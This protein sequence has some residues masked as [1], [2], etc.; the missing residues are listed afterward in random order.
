MS[1]IEQLLAGITPEMMSGITGGGAQAPMGGQLSMP[2][3]M[4]MAAQ[5]PPMPQAPP[6]QPPQD[7]PMGGL[8]GNPL[9]GAGMGLLASGYDSRVN[10]WTSAM[11]GMMNMQMMKNRSQLT[12]AKKDEIGIKQENLKLERERMK[13]VSDMAKGA[14]KN[15]D[16]DQDGQI[17]AIEN[18]RGLLLRLADQTGD[19]KYIA[20]ASKLL[21]SQLTPTAKGRDWEGL[22]QEGGPDWTPGDPFTEAQRQ[23]LLSS[24][25]AYGQY[26]VGLQNQL[27]AQEERQTFA[28]DYRKER[29]AARDAITKL[30][31]ALIKAEQINTG[32]LS[33]IK[34]FTDADLQ[35]FQAMLADIGL[36]RLGSLPVPLTPM[37]DP[38]IKLILSLSGSIT[39]QPEANVR[40]LTRTLGAA[41]RLA[42]DMDATAGW[43]SNPSNNSVTDPQGLFN[44]ILMSRYKKGLDAPPEEAPAAEGYSDLPGPK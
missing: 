8:M 13:A 20:A 25:A 28:A 22:V 30:E 19:A 27:G 18:Q 9:L 15:L 40:L 32:V 44:H 3:V 26:D 23:R 12:A 16:V 36:D 1:I 43:Y 33:G 4:G 6:Q 11:Q 2:A 34:Q 39:N 21:E 5:Q 31:R 24:G 41:K 10:P 42:S 37:S 35:E 7:D 14:L 29:P 38:D 17:S